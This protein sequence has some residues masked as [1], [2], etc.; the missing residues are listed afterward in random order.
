MRKLLIIALA[1]VAVSFSACKSEGIKTENGYRFF[2]HTNTGGVKPQPGE[3]VLVQSYVWIGDS[4]MSSSVKRFGGPQEYTLYPKDQLPERIPALY[5]AMLLMGEGDSATIFEPI[6]TFIRKF[7]PPSLKDAKEVRHEL[8]LVDV[9]SKEEKEKSM[10]MAE[11]KYQSVK[12]KTQ[13]LAKE[14][15]AGKLSSQL[16]AMESGLK[17]LI[18]EK[19]SGAAI[20]PGEQVKVHYYGCLTNGEMF[21]NSYQRGEPYPFPAGVGQMITGFDEGVMQ[22]NHGGKAHFFIPSS[23]GYGDQ[24][25]GQIP[26]NS[27]LIFYVEVL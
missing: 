26:P 18:E 2:N 24:A 10:A 15:S 14:Y 25:A 23:L 4:L 11:A 22:L 6:D 20:K 27:E 7:V 12:N 5:D 17:I 3:S 21:D 13:D 8:V 9:I 1:A 19:G 16:T